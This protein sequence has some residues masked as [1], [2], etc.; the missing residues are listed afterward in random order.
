M[1]PS[2]IEPFLLFIAFAFQGGGQTLTPRKVADEIES[3]RARANPLLVKF[4]IDYDSDESLLSAARGSIRPV[5]AEATL[6]LDS[7]KQHC[8]T[9]SLSIL[10]EAA[11]E[12]EMT[13]VFTGDR[14]LIRQEKQ[15]QIQSEKSAFCSMNAYTS[16]LLWPITENELRS[17]REL[18]AK[19]PFLPAMLRDGD[20]EV[21]EGLEEQGGVQ[22]LTLAT[23]DGKNQLWLDTRKSHALIRY[24]VIRPFPGCSRI[25]TRYYENVHV[26]EGLYL[27]R[28]IVSVRTVVDTKD[29]ELGQRTNTLSVTEI[30]VGAL[31]SG[32]FE[33]RPKVG[34]TVVDQVSKQ[35]YQYYPTDDRSLDRSI[36]MAR[37]A[38]SLEET[39]RS[40][41]IWLCAIA[42][43]G[44]LFVGY[45]SAKLFG[46][47]KNKSV[48]RHA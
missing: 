27:P 4:R 30:R 44:A 40:R 31:P 29:L 46:R 28:R 16:L 23:R 22:C 21:K 8:T 32:L 9:H 12:T 41:S 39:W 37:P 13:A 38:I 24:L 26:A 15:L 10:D 47:L 33:L 45:G 17:A 11:Q 42:S 3:A 35:V 19:A 14:S 25:D 2:V 5:W 18:G 20:W 7:P 34:E 6:A 43:L 48:S 36:D 1:L